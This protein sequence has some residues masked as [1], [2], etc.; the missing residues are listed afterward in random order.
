M[1]CHLAVLLAFTPSGI[2]PPQRAR[3]NYPLGGINPR[4]G[5]VTTIL[6]AARAGP[7]GGSPVAG[8]AFSSLTT[9]EKVAMVRVVDCNGVS[10]GPLKAPQKKPEWA[11]LTNETWIE[12]KAEYPELSE[13]SED[14]LA[15]AWNELKSGNVGAGSSA[16]PGDGAV[17]VGIA[18]A[19]F[20]AAG[21]ALNIDGL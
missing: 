19:L 2:N 3:R 21:V 18:V 9:E 15:A 14:V 16:E 5:V 6:R 20:L 4:P 7:R 13:C 11:I 17:P 8:E 12:V 1:I 10:E